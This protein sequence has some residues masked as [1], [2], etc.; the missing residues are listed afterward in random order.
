LYLNG[1]KVASLK[2]S[3]SARPDDTPVVLP[4][5]KGWNLVTMAS[6]RAS[7]GE[8]RLQIQVQSAVPV[9]LSATGPETTT[10]ASEE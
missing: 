8:N 10:A 6:D 9:K 1:V 2:P 5:K 3:V 4:L 7:V